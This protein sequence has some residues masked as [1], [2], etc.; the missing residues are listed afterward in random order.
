[1]IDIACQIHLNVHSYEDCS[2]AE[3]Q[4]CVEYEYPIEFPIFRFAIIRTQKRVQASEEE[5]D[6]DSLIIKFES[7]R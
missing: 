5:D 2:Q 1:M 7:I 4:K 3:E 6:H